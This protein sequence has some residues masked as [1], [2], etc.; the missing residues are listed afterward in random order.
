M[1]CLIVT[2]PLSSM[3]VLQLFL[4]FINHSLRFE[5]AYKSRTNPAISSLVNCVCAAVVRAVVPGL[6]QIGLFV[7]LNDSIENPVPAPSG[8]AK[9]AGLT[10]AG[11]WLYVF[12]LNK[13]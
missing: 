9:S 11:N 7:V 1:L 8:T 12:P 2:S 13:V 4:V 6:G 10:P 3:N 5:D